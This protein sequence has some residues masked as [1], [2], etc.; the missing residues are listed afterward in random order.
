MTI[1]FTAATFGK[2]HYLSNYLKIIGILKAK[3]YQVISDHI[4]NSDGPDAIS[5]NGSQTEKW[6]NSSDFVIA[7]TSSPSISVGYEIS[8]ALHMG[9]PV[10]LLYA[11]DNPPSLLAQHSD[12]KLICEKYTP[13]TLPGIIDNFLSFTGDNGDFRYTFFITRKMAEYL[14]QIAKRERLPKSVYLR[15]LIQKDMAANHL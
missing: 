12:E 9:K 3:N 6:I 2:K 8:I 11:T 7:E 5:H 13:G 14:K 15:S 4:I 10:L 1:Y